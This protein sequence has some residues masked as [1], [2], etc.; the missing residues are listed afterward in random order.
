MYWGEQFVN[1]AW[2]TN[3]YDWYPLLDEKGKLKKLT[4]SRK[5]RF[6]SMLTECGPPAIVTGQV[7]VLFYNGKT[8][9]NDDCDPT[10]PRGTYSV[11][12]VVFDKKKTCSL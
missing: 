12:K 11:K 1:L 2:S 5:G 7:I 4:T 3:L 6:D 10:L 9:D 8:A